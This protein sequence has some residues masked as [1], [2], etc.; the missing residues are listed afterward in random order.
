MRK[1]SWAICFILL[2]AVIYVTYVFAAWIIK[3]QIIIAVMIAVT[4]WIITHRLNIKANDKSF[5][6][7]IVNH[8]R[9]EIIKAIHEYDDWLRKVNVRMYTLSGELLS[10]KS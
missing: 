4:G 9:V 10:W 8:S 5:L 3:Q 6:N 2:V 7:Q 1:L